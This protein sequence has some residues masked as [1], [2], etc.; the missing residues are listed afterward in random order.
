MTKDQPTLTLEDLR[1]A[2]RAGVCPT[3][4]G[5]LTWAGDVRRYVAPCCSLRI[6]STFRGFALSSEADHHTPEVGYGGSSNIYLSNPEALK[7]TDHDPFLGQATKDETDTCGHCGASC[8]PTHKVVG[9]VPDGRG[10]RTRA[11]GYICKACY[12]SLV[13]PGPVSIGYTTKGLRP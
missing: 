13:D 5:T 3:H 11:T 4:A 10:G 8:P 9:T 6:S 7:Q 1:A 12:A 2:L